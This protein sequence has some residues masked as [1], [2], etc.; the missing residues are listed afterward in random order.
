MDVFVRSVQKVAVANNEIDYRILFSA[1]AEVVKFR[2]VG[3]VAAK[4]VVDLPSIMIAGRDL[5]VGVLVAL[6]AWPRQSL[7]LV[8]F[9]RLDKGKVRVSVAPGAVVVYAKVYKPLLKPILE[10]ELFILGRNGFY[11]FAGVDGQYA[12]LKDIEAGRCLHGSP[13]DGV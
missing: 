13:D 5:A 11:Q 10:M 4:D 12:L 8:T 9:G 3:W 6:A 2:K 1:S 7:Y